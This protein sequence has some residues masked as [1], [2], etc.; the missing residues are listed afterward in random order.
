MP[1]VR[2]CVTSFRPMAKIAELALVFK[3]RENSR[4]FFLPAQLTRPR[5]IEL[6][7]IR[8]AENEL[9]DYIRA[10]GLGDLFDEAMLRFL[11]Q[12]E[13]AKTFGSLIQPSV[14]GDTIAFARRAIEVKDLGSQ[15]FLHET[16]IKVLRALE[17]GKAMNGKLKSFAAALYPTTKADLFSMFIEQGRRLL[18]ENG[19]LAQITMQSWMF[20]SSFSKMRAE[21]VLAYKIETCIHIGYNS[22]PE[23]NSKVAQAV[24][25]VIC[26]H[27]ANNRGGKFFDLNSAPQS[28]DKHEVF[29]TKLADGEFYLVSNAQF[30]AIPGAPLAYWASPGVL[31]LFSN[32]PGVGDSVEAR[33]GL[34]TADN[35]RFLRRWWEVA[36]NRTLFPSEYSEDARQSKKWFPYNKG[37]DFRKWYGNAE[38]VVNWENDG[39]AIKGFVDAGGDQMSRPQNT[40]FYFCESIS[41]SDVTTDWNSFR[42]YP[43]GFIFDATGH[44][45]FPRREEIPEL[46]AYLNTRIVQQIAKLLNPTIHF[47]VG[48]F[49]LLPFTSIANEAVNQNARSAV[50]MARSDWDNFET[51]WDFGRQPMLR[52]ELKGATLRASWQS[53]EAQAVAAVRRMQDLETENNRVFINAY[54]LDGELQCEVPKDQITLA[55]AEA[56]R[57][58]VA[59]L[60]YAVGCMMG[61]YSLDQ[62]GLIL[63]GA[64]ESRSEFLEKVRLP[65]ETLSFVPDE[66]G[67]IPLLDGEWFEDD[68]VARTR[69]F[70]RA[71]FGEA[72]LRENVEFIEESLGRDLRKYFPTDFYK[73]HLR[74]YK[75]R[76]IYW[77]IQS[78]HKGFSVLVYLHR[79]TR[80]TMNLVLNRY[81]REFQA[82]LRNRLAH[83]AR[84]QISVT[85]SA[86]DKTAARKESD[87]LTRTLHECEEW[88]RE[89]LLPLAQARIELDLDEGVKTNY[90]KLGEALAPIPGLAAAEED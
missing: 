22:F 80:D 49:R 72:T 82:K 43:A 88:E 6:R 69:D 87:K 1:D 67:I 23:L 28:A 57:D 15:L 75:K 63:A 53:W 68:I 51:S 34:I 73:D 4:R 64:G 44:S 70:L 54:G 48:Y 76:P 13:E 30:R 32:A 83:L 24:A 12:F 46:L 59:L 85:I 90:L 8:F 60:S 31:R 61:R 47:H 35:D 39:E 10:L 89:T 29:T 56:R 62:P 36:C 40:Q 16:H 55:H 86:R 71:T 25:F 84:T 79:Y 38:Y 41:W 21:V 19:F 17:Q 78:P 7:E 9:R 14:D 50:A 20:L 27:S 52:P 66:D 65:K 2:A 18:V 26:N 42:W 58:V 77:L 81:L 45:A 74:T 3:A 11:H 33:Q 37:G 5:I